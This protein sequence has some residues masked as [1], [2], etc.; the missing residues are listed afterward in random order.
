ML[1]QIN[2]NKQYL[3]DWNCAIGAN[4]QSGQCNKQYF[5]IFGS[6]YV[7]FKHIKS[8]KLLSVT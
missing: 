5:T 1:I 4:K 6:N 7:P 3:R 2:N 8:K